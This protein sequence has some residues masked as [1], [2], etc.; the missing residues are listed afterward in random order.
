MNFA[1]LL[2][3]AQNCQFVK[4][5]LPTTSSGAGFL[6]PLIGKSPPM[7]SSCFCFAEN[8]LH[9]CVDVGAHQCSKACRLGSLSI[10]APDQF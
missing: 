3:M 4:A 10:K 8:A 9:V 6:D 1:K 2:L 5:Q 7:C